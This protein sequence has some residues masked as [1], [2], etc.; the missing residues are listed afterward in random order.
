[1]IV[2]KVL[3]Q[4]WDTRTTHYTHVG[5]MTLHRCHQLHD[6]YC[7]FVYIYIIILVRLFVQTITRAF[8]RLGASG[9][10]RA[11]LWV[12]GRSSSLKL[13]CLYPSSEDPVSAASPCLSM[14]RHF[15]RPRSALQLRRSLPHGSRPEDGLLLVYKKQPDLIYSTSAAV[16]STLHTVSDNDVGYHRSNMCVMCSTSV[17]TLFQYFFYDHISTF[18][19]IL[20]KCF[21]LLV[22]ML[23]SCFSTPQACVSWCIL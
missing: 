11:L 8:V 9:S 19:Y 20:M 7:L 15:V 5:P 1:M 3:E 6:L 12:A 21:L 18:L 10:T 23:F 16:L 14:G 22:C 13:S 17:P 4:G 2:K